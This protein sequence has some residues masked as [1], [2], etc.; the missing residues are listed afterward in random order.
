VFALFLHK[1]LNPGF[2]SFVS[3]RPSPWEDR[4]KLYPIDS[5]IYI[6]A[7]CDPVNVL[8]DSLALSSQQLESP[9]PA[10]SYW[11]GDCF[12]CLPWELRELIA[13]LLPTEDALNL[14]LASR[15]FLRIFDSQTFWLS[16]F[17]ATGDRGFVFEVHKENMF[18]D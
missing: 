16:R 17:Q 15:S 4:F 9:L 10:Y 13:I 11:T 5:Q 6:S 1:G 18:L 7:R 12:G 8:L 2:A 3:V 14:R